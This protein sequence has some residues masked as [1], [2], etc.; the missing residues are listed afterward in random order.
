MIRID[1]QRGFGVSH[2]LLI[3]AQARQRDAQVVMR[4]RVFGIGA[5]RLAV[6][7]DAL[8]HLPLIDQRQ[9]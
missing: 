1:R 4:I 3:L 6:A 7:F 8:C 9:A 2:R 5:Q